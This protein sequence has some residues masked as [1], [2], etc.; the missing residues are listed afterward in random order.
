MGKLAIAKSDKIKVKNFANVIAGK[1][2]DYLKD[3]T[4]V[5]E[6]KKSSRS[7]IINQTIHAKFK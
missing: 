3:L 7:C 6:S 1:H 5:A 2:Q 4:A